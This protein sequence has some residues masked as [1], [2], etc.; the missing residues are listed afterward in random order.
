M[1]CK[2]AW[3]TLVFILAAS[4]VQAGGGR[5]RVMGSEAIMPP[6]RA[7]LTIDGDLRDWDASQAKLLTLFVGGGEDSQSPAPL[8]RYSAKVSFQYDREALYVACWWNDPTPLGPESSAASTPPGDGLILDLPLHDMVHVACWREPGTGKTRAVLAVGDTPLAKGR[9]LKDVAQGYQTTGKNAYTQELRLPW[10]E[11]GGRLEP[12]AMYRLGLELCFG[13]LDPAA[14][15]K[16]WQADSKAGVSSSGNR[17]GGNMGWGFVDGL[18]SRELVAPS[19]DPATGAEVKLLPAGSAAPANPA[20]LYVGNEQTRTTAMIALPAGRMNVDGKLDAG[21]WQETSATTVASEPSLFPNRYAVDVHWAYDAQGLYAGLRWRTG[22]PHLNINNPSV[23]NRGYDGGDALQMRLGTD[24]VSHVD[25]WYF[26]EGKRPALVIDYGARF[27]EGK[28]PDAIAKG[29]KLAIQATPGGGYTEEIFLPWALL[30]S[31]G[32]P[33]TEGDAF[34]VVLDVFFSG[35]EGN[36]IPYIVNTRVAE[37]TGVVALPF[38]APEEGYYSVVIEDSARGRVVRRLLTLEKLRQGQVLGEWDGLDDAGRLV[39]PGPYRFRGLR[40]QGIGTKYLMTY[41]NPGN[42]PW[43]NDSGSGEWGG[44]HASPQAVAVDA[45]GVYLGWPAAEDGNGI[46]GCDREGHK[47]WGFFGTPANQGYGDSGS[48]CL[49]ADGGKVFYASEVHI[50][51][52]PKGATALAYFK[53]AVACLDTAKGFRTGVSLKEPYSVIATHDTSQVQV[54]WFWNLYEKK[55][56]SLDTYAIHDEY[57]Y[58]GRVLGGNLCGLAASAGKLYA[59]LRISGEIAVYD[60]ADMKELARWKLA[61]PAGLA[62][63]PGGVLF[64][65]SDKSVVRL[66]LTTG[67][68]TPVVTTGLE[69]PVGLAAAADGTL[70]VSEW[71]TAQCVKVFDAK[72][73]AVRSIGTPGGRAWVGQYDPKGMLLPRGIALDKENRLWVCE[74][75]SQPRRISLWDARS[76]ALLQEFVG[77]TIYGGVNGGMIDPQDPSRAV[78]AGC[79]FQIDLAKEGC[80]P[81]TSIWRRLSREQY[82]GFGPAQATNSAA[83]TRFVDYRG[84]RFVLSQ[85]G[86]AV[87]IGELRPDG[88][89]LPLAAVG[90]IF[91]RGD[92]AEALPDAKLTWR[93]RLAPAFFAQH[94]GEN[95]VWTDAN[96]DGALQENEFQWRKQEPKTFPCW[97]GYWGPGMVDREF[98]VYIAADNHGLIARFPLQGWSERGVP[99]YDINRCELV[100]SGVE[101]GLGA[102]AVDKGGQVFS[103]AEAA[104]WRWMN[105]RTPALAA[106]GPD[107]KLRWSI[108]T[109]EDARPSANLN[110]ECIMGPIDLGG[111]VGEVI[112]TSQWH[113]LHV[114]LITT[115]GIYFARL[116]RDPAEGGEPGPDMWRGET[117]QYL[118]RLADG[119][120]ILAHGK[121]AHHMLQVTGLETL[122]RFGGDFVL[123]PDQAGQAAVRQ[124]ARRSQAEGAAPL[125]IVWPARGTTARTGGSDGQ[126]DDWDWTV[127]GSIGPKD[128]TPRAEVALR[129][130]DKRDKWGNPLEFQ[131]AFKV[132]KNGPFLNTAK[133]DALRLFLTGDAVDLQFATDP[134]ARPGRREAGLGDCRLVFS[135][136]DGRPVAVLYRAQ[137]PNAKQPVGF[138]SPVRTVTFDA[139]E[140]VKDATVAI[141]DT[142]EGYNVEASLPLKLLAGD[143]P[144]GLWPGRILPGDAGIVVADKSGRRV[145]RV[146]RFNRDTGIVN[147]VPSEAVLAPHQWG[148]LVVDQEATKK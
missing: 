26:D 5:N 116:L 37:P 32:Q 19:F 25:A 145:A 146:Y 42:P 94:A 49:A 77:G 126:L 46:I 93:M 99:R 58:S 75:D 80:R 78:S 30:T 122:K 55:D 22:G 69:A 74:D 92:N 120:V 57:F 103:V 147:D 137:V 148:Q 45:D 141:A 48:S 88:T 113:G 44:D 124:Q 76:G 89:W 112:G 47:R 23:L 34:R 33:L 138:S 86:A 98:N 62:F 85:T 136:L 73:Q 27:N 132:F 102:L 135:K 87:V 52:P 3:L 143:A 133:D 105:G 24:R 83:S 68:A 54:N 56:F 128:G 35:L 81:L 96:G 71:G 100:A 31:K 12:G 125:R 59:S 43:Q 134:A 20:V 121:N 40:H 9:E 60:S 90:G 114:P 91:K 111:E 115:D 117:I 108:P 110:G 53:T 66:D 7:P 2:T 8:E 1:I 61:K 10:R 129:V 50:N 127:A 16:A 67:A 13:G 140:L 11:L 14:G 97:G 36:R 18:R 38:T 15:Y 107:G 131:V 70:Y 28:E 95:Y 17:W 130:G 65:I 64:A 139:V 106:H 63:T 123:T 79:W 109:S 142:A 82:F 39:D 119:R 6:L 21:E 4:A 41:N 104:C 118:N 84:R 144:A 29:A 101:S 51:N 72:G